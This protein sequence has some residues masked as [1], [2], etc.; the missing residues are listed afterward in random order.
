MNC[1]HEMIQ[2]QTVNAEIKVCRDCKKSKLEIERDEAIAMFDDA[3]GPCTESADSG[4]PVKHLPPACEIFGWRKELC[5]FQD[6]A[7][8]VRFILDHEGWHVLLEHELLVSSGLAGSSYVYGVSSESVEDAAECLL[9]MLKA[10]PIRLSRG[11]YLLWDP[12]YG[13]WSEYS[14][15]DEAVRAQGPRLA[16]PK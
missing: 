9:K 4:L 16:I 6:K 1:N 15:L 14:S 11:E 7:I 5:Q 12:K 10:G 2:T 3:C 13:A 8:K